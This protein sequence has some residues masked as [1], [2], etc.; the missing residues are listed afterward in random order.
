MASI[1]CVD[2]EASVRAA[3]EAALTKL[4]HVTTLASAVDE[5]MKAVAQQPFDL[6]ISDY[7]MPQATGVDLLARLA[8][9]GYRIPVVIMTGYTAVEHAVAAVRKG[10]VDYLTKPVRAEALRIIVTQ[11]LE[12]TRLQQANERLRQE[13]AALRV[14]QQI[15][16]ASEVLEQLLAVGSLI[17]PLRTPV[18]LQG[19][20]GTGKKLLARAI[21][22]QS[23]R[24]DRPFVTVDCEAM[25]EGLL[26]SALFGQDKGAGAGS[27]PVQGAFERADGGTLLLDHVG[28]LRLDLQARLVRVIHHLELK[29]VGGQ[30]P[31]PV[32]VR[33]IATTT[34][35]LRAEAAAGRFRW[36]LYHRLSTVPLAVP[37]LRERAEDIPVLAHHFANR[38]AAQLG[39]EPGPISPEAIAT[40]QARRWPGNVQELAGAVERALVL[41]RGDV[42]TAEAFADPVVA[43][44]PAGAWAP[45]PSPAAG[46]TAPGE[47]AG[48]ALPTV[49]LDELE[50]I[51]IQ[52]AL[53]ATKGNRTR[54]AKLLGISERTLRN[55]LNSPRVATPS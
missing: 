54:A 49:N 55:K 26:E 40:L 7:R 45:E 32:D 46:A 30:Q 43:D 51:A 1:L 31:I 39:V 24:R 8:K 25:P 6:I 3:I 21:H 28:R 53:E 2:D 48:S 44:R 16:G 27:A 41:C 10:A 19:E 35:D 11:V 13:I 50:R 15:L 38:A 4:G 42:L 33:V 14:R 29:R 23:P 9:E 52:R 12:V 22:D 47:A 17:A 36:D 34:R 37:P 18:L 20:P 5:A